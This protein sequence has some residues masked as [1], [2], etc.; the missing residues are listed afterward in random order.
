M[1]LADSIAQQS[2]RYIKTGGGATTLPGV[3]PPTPPLVKQPEKWEKTAAR[4]K[5]SVG[6]AACSAL[7]L[8]VVSSWWGT[9]PKVICQGIISSSFGC[10]PSKTAVA[11]ETCPAWTFDATPR[12]RRRRTRSEG[13]FSRM[14]IDFPSVFS[15]STGHAG[16]QHRGRTR[17]AKARR[18]GRRMKCPRVL[19]YW[20]PV[21][22][23]V[24]VWARVLARR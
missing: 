24:S 6:A 19:T 2:V 7:G 9:G 11:E 14:C 20:Y 15:K 23:V 8:A 18:G 5:M 16:F 13:P 17:A 12:G 1:R 3:L 21:G 10:F 22:A 4:H